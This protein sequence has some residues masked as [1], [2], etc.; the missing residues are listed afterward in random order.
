[1]L[2]GR[3]VP[4]SWGDG[5]ILA[6]EGGAQIAMRQMAQIDQILLDQRLVEIVGGLDILL[7]I[8]RQMTLAVERAAGAARIMKKVMVTMTNRVGNAPRKR[9]RAKPSMPL[10]LPRGHQ[11]FNGGG[12]RCQCAVLNVFGPRSASALSPRHHAQATSHRRSRRPCRNGW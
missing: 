12:G 3:P 2:T 10:R 8:R 9:R 7:D 4:I 5:E 6:L 11:Q 1:M